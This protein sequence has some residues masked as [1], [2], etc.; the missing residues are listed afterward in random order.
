MQSK[1]SVQI[2]SYRKINKIPKAWSNKDFKTML[3]MMDYDD[4]DS[5][6]DSELREMCVMSLGDLEPD[7]GAVIVLTHLFPSLKRGKIEQMAHDML[8]DRSWEEYPD[9]LF[10]ERFFNA[11]ELL[12]DAYGSKFAKPT[13]VEMTLTVSAAHAEDLA[14]F[15]QSLAP[16]MVRLLA[17]GLEDNAL[18]HRLYEE[19]IQGKNFPE[20][21]GLVWQLKQVAESGSSRQFSLVSSY[22]WLQSFEQVDS[23]EAISHADAAS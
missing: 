7:E 12:R 4:V 1:F 15:D 21:A 13:G 14:I 23:F 18:M 19:Q 8:E 9:C 2:D 6:D 22:F 10:H 17:S 11:Y 3:S 16:S 5:I 20:A